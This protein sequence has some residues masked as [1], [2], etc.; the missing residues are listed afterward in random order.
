LALDFTYGESPHVLCAAST[1]I[2]QYWARTLRRRPI[3]IY[4]YGD[5]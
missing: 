2:M 5:D 4:I 3:S 1:L